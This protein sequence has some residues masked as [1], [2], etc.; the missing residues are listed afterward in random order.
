MKTSY[1]LFAKDTPESPGKREVI[2]KV[3]DHWNQ[4][5]GQGCWKGHRL[6]TYEI[7]AVIAEALTRYSVEDI[8][9]AISN[10]AMVLLDDRFYWTYAWSLH[11]FLATGCGSGKSKFELKKWWRFLPDNFNRSEYLK[12]RPETAILTDP[13]PELTQRIVKSFG[14]IIN[15][16]AYIP[17]EEELAKFVMATIRM[18]NF[19]EK[20]ELPKTEWVRYLTRCIVKNYIDDGRTVFPGVMASRQVWEILLPQYLKSIGVEM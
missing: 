7:K 12:N 1:E 14:R 20:R 18:I 16:T 8:C 2:Q 11:S 5:R 3:F 13:D 4:Y 17:S 9:S 6:L 15:N 10:Y 19:F